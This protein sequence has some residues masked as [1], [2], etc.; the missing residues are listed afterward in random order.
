MIDELEAL[1]DQVKIKANGFRKE[2]LHVHA[3][4]LPAKGKKRAAIVTN[5]LKNRQVSRQRKA[6]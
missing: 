4:A 1:A 2:L 3:G 5:V 6:S